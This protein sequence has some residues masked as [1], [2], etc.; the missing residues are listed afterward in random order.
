MDGGISFLL[1]KSTG[2]LTLS[3][4]LWITGLVILKVYFGMVRDFGK[5]SFEGEGVMPLM[6]NPSSCR[7]LVPSSCSVKR[8][9]SSMVFVG[10]NGFR[11]PAFACVY[12]IA[13]A[14]SGSVSMLTLLKPSGLALRISAWARKLLLSYLLAGNFGKPLAASALFLIYF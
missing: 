5:R 3:C 12:G 9:L 7:A 10:L 1:R 4:L 8:G 11:F 13:C 6:L 14:N 2:G